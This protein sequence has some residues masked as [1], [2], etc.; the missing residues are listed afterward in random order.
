MS[1][2]NP[3]SISP[4]ITNLYI[5]G[6]ITDG[7]TTSNPMGYALMTLNGA[8]FPNNMATGTNP[9]FVAFSFGQQIGED[10]N[11]FLV[12]CETAF[13]IDSLAGAQGNYSYVTCPS[14]TPYL[15]GTG[16][17]GANLPQVCAGCSLSNIIASATGSSG[18]LG[19]YNPSGGSGGSGGGGT[20]GGYAGSYNGYTSGASYG[21]YGGTLVTCNAANPDPTVFPTCGTLDFTAAGMSSGASYFSDPTQAA[22]I[23]DVLSSVQGV[24]TAVANY[25]AANNGQWPNVDQIG[26]ANSGQWYQVA[27]PSSISPMFSGINIGS[28]EPDGAPG[29]TPNDGQQFWF[30][31]ANV[32]GAVAGDNINIVFGVMPGTNNIV[33]GCNLTFG[34]VDQ[35]GFCSHTNSEVRNQIHTLW[36][37]YC[38]TGCGPGFNGW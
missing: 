6:T 2:T 10:N 26:I 31:P 27:D 17:G 1:L 14:G 12:G 32:P 3:Q 35:P 9:G 22:A 37:P 29:S 20:L 7:T 23:D 16:N 15:G 4:Y 24:L 28:G 38:V 13:S 36:S 18:Y 8:S 34:G 33:I 5:P 30:D 11:P 25:Y 19:A 21:G